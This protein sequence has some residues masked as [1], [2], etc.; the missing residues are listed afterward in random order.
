M[1]RAGSVFLSISIGFLLLLTP[2][3]IVGAIKDLVTISP[4]M[5]QWQSQLIFAVFPIGMLLYIVSLVKI[6]KWFARNDAAFIEKRLNE[7]LNE[8]N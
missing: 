4:S 6:G 2:I 7:I 5:T 3:F 8:R 1:R